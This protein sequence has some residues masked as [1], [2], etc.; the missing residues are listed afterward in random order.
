MNELWT[1]FVV[2]F[3]ALFPICNP[4]GNAAIFLSITQGDTV[5]ERHQ[6]ALK[7]SIYMVI[8]L[9]VF[10]LGGTAILQFFG[11]SLASVRLAGAL[12]VGIV[13]IRMMN[14]K[15]EHTHTPEEESAAKQKDDVSFTPLA[16]PL[17]AGPGSIAV[18]MNMSA[19]QT[20][21]ISLGMLGLGI[22]ILLVAFTCFVIL[23]NADRL[24]KLLGVNG[25]NAL[26]RIMALLLLCI[27][28]QLGLDGIGQWMA[29]APKS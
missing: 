1:S 9:F 13:A 19:H 6:T 18:V 20:K 24:M 25:A 29:S 17:L 11:I 14:P 5:S 16:I 7:A 12:V 15:K 22:G 27:A 4:L 21:F 28:V 3:A 26:T 23:R 2:A 10:C 8:L